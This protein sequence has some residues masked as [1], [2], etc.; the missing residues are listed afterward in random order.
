ML[1]NLLNPPPTPHLRKVKSSWRHRIAGL[2]LAATS[3][4]YSGCPQSIPPGSQFA[5]SYDT[6]E[7]QE[8]MGD[9]HK[10][11]SYKGDSE[12]LGDNGLEDE[13]KDYSIE[14]LLHDIFFPPEAKVEETDN[15]VDQANYDLPKDATVQDSDDAFETG[16][17]GQLPDILV[18]E[19]NFPEVLPEVLPEATMELP[20]E[21]NPGDLYNPDLDDNGPDLPLPDNGGET[22][23]PAIVPEVGGELAEVAVP[24]IAGELYLPEI[25]SEVSNPDDTKIPSADTVDIGEDVPP[26]IPPCTKKTYYKDADKDSFGV[27][28]DSQELCEPVFPYTAS[29]IGD[30]DDNDLMANP[31]G[32]EICDGKDND[33]NKNTDENLEGTCNDDKEIAQFVCNLEKG[34]YLVD[35][36]GGVPM[37]NI[38]VGSIKYGENCTYFDSAKKSCLE[39]KTIIIGEERIAHLKGLPV[40]YTVWVPEQNTCNGKKFSQEGNNTDGSDQDCNKIVDDGLGLMSLVAGKDFDG[41]LIFFQMGCDP[42]NNP[43]CLGDNPSKTFALNYNYWI[44]KNMIT[45]AQYQACV[46]GKGCSEIAET[47]KMKGV[48]GYPEYFTVP[49]NHGKLP[50]VYL[51][52]EQ[53]NQFCEW[54]GKQ[55]PSEYQ[56]EKAARGTDGRIYPWGNNPPKADGSDLLLNWNNLYGPGD[57]SKGMP[58]G[59][60]TEVGSFPKGD[61]PYLIHDMAGLAVEWMGDFYQVTAYS[62]AQMINPEGP[63]SGSNRVMRNVGTWSTSLANMNNLLAYFRSQQKPDY[64]SQITGARCVLKK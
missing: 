40:K 11:D 23:I 59:G 58:T 44:D 32:I 46:K 56:W 62:N 50:Q 5:S 63:T 6:Q 48:F 43:N 60:L 24:E 8:V 51:T 3:L 2:S 28:G 7:V 55:L 18:T 14:D 52:W 47:S 49:E 42:A 15:G 37:E 12:N 21:I 41:N 16:D 36:C 34:K 61:S 38:P 64:S 22:E 57:L 31:L 35:S 4:F 1:E 13:G 45:V 30:C 25:L 26:E 20:P 9:N 10:G 39:A 19:V 17:P 29:K 54:A 53:A 27:A 33:C